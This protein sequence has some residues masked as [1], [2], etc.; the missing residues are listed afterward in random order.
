MGQTDAARVGATLARVYMAQVLLPYQ[1]RWILDRSR[2]KVACWSRQSGKSFAEGLSAVLG[3]LGGRN[4]LLIAASQRQSF[5]VMERV[6]LHL[7]GLQA[8]LDYGFKIL[9]RAAPRLVDGRPGK[10][11]T[12]LTTGAK[13]LALPA[14]PET[15]RGFSGDLHLDEAAV[16]SRD[17]E[18][19]RAIFPIATR[20]GY[21]VSVTSTPFGD[22][23]LFHR[24]WTSDGDRWSKHLVTIDDAISQGLVIDWPAIQEAIGDPDAIAQEY[25]CE[26]LSDALKYFP[27]DLVRSCLY[28]DSMK[29]HGAKVVSYGGFDIG[30][31]KDLTAWCRLEMDQRDIR[32]VVPGFTMEKTKYG[33]QEKRLGDEIIAQGVRKTCGDRSGIGDH[34][35]ENLSRAPW[36][37]IGKSMSMPFKEELCT[38]V[39]KLM[40]QGTLKIPMGW[41]ALV[42]SMGMIRRSVTTQNNLIFDSERNKHGHADEFWAMALA[43]HAAPRLH[44]SAPAARMGGRRRQRG[45]M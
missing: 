13:I 29:I 1:R 34:L 2:Y 16:V 37:V 18:L 12:R 15:V 30:R 32:W 22:Q 19:W 11:E 8:A 45:I 26:F 31:H 28:D 41:P 5:E 40:Q 3:A 9:G 10:A 33:V 27:S 23:G 43:V 42:R 4:Q 44:T 21:R 39:K 20:G 14:S 36:G 24:L 6:G 7:R 25:R 38:T 35:C 17:E